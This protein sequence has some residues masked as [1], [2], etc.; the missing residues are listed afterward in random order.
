M[1]SQ[2]GCLSLEDPEEVE[3]WLLSLEAKARTQMKKGKQDK[4]HMVDLLI[5]KCGFEA[6]K[7][8]RMLLAPKLVE[9]C[10]Y[11]EIRAAIMNYVRPHE[12]LIIAERTKFMN[13]EQISGESESDFHLRLKA[14]AKHCQF[15]D[16]RNSDDPE[17]DLIK[18]KFVAGLSDKPLKLKILEYLSL[19]KEATVEDL[20]NHCI[21]VR[22]TQ[23]FVEN[24]KGKSEVNSHNDSSLCLQ[25]E[26]INAARPSSAPCHSC[27]SR[28]LPR[29]CPA[30]GKWCTACGK[31]NHFANVCRSSRSFEQIKSTR[32]G[33]A[34]HSAKCVEAIE[35]RIDSHHSSSS[36]GGMAN[37][38]VPSDNVWWLE[39]EVNMMEAKKV[40]VSLPEYSAL[41]DMMV[42]TGATV[43]LISTDM[44]ANLVI[45][46]PM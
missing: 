46:C 19:K 7:K 8:V 4:S 13:Q 39:N 28:H 15:S 43:S 35:T 42:D 37:K 31:R 1:A 18:M 29:H 16:L 33:F 5:S 24:P 40:V 3:C 10:S 30:F 25:T 2:A 9:K 20:L 17:Q 22:A 11:Q 21:N 34:N 26:Q 38:G 32:H 45:V 41:L 6:L 27:G 36:P 44:W 23:D 14:A 12:R